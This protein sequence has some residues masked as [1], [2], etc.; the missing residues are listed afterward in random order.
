MNKTGQYKPVPPK[1]HQF[2]P[3]QSGN[4][5]GKP[6]VLYDIMRAARKASPDAFRSIVAISKDPKASAAIRLKASEFII[7]RAFGRAQIPL[8]MDG[9]VEINHRALHLDAL[10]LVNGQAEAERLLER[11]EQSGKV[12]DDDSYRDVTSDDEDNTSTDDK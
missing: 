7:E 8:H 5:G 12:I 2:K 1:E 6:K 11:A 4:P 3:G 10:K 9:S